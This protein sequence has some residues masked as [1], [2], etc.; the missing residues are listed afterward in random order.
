MTHASCP[1][2]DVYELQELNVTTGPVLGDTEGTRRSQ[3]LQKSEQD[4]RMPSQ[5]MPS[6]ESLDVIEDA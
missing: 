2:C 6:A 4:E 3:P 5:G 1:V